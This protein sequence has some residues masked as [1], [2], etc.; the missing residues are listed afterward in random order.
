M[1][2]SILSGN[3]HSYLYQAVWAAISSK[4]GIIFGSAILLGSCTRAMEQKQTVASATIPSAPV[5]KPISGPLT[6]KLHQTYVLD[7]NVQYAIDSVEKSKYLGQTSKGRTAGEGALF[8][9]V[10]FRAK[11]NGKT[12]TTV[13]TDK[14]QTQTADGQTY[15]PSGAGEA[16]V[17]MNGGPK[18]LFG[19]QLEPSTA[20]SFLAIFDIPIISFNSGADLI[21][22]SS[23][24]RS[25][26]RWVVRLNS[27]E[28][29]H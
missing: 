11:N 3:Q 7:D 10:R 13:A 6:S 12:T 27:S 25:S 22:P 2:F 15:S 19:S 14:F 5:L 24:L 4:A 1:G 8:Y 20:K 29:R 28:R 16:A 21:V 23:N 26:D 9:I 18:D 17:L